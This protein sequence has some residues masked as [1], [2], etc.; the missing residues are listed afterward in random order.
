MR[1]QEI[2]AVLA[3][4]EPPVS[5]EDVVAAAGDVE[6]ESPQGVTETVAD[7][8][9]RQGAETYGSVAEV[10]MAVRAGV[11]WEFVGRREYDDRSPNHGHHEQMSF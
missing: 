3:E 5:D 2:D 11:G 1:L 9:E 8:L 6:L 10:A 7:A 4:L